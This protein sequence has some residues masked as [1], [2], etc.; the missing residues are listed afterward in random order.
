MLI[1]CCTC[2]WV[3]VRIAMAGWLHGVF[4]GDFL[5]IHCVAS[6]FQSFVTTWIVGDLC[7][8][9]SLSVPGVWSCLRVT[10]RNDQKSHK[11]YHGLHVPPE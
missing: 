3:F 8:L 11:S 4:V 9:W 7:G 1:L 5:F 2:V 10:H 6:P